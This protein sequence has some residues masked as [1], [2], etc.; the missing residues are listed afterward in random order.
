MALL[1]KSH[2]NTV[3][4]SISYVILDTETR[5]CWI[6]DVGDFEIINQI[7]E[8]YDLQGVFLTHIHYD[9]IYGLDKLHRIYPH[10]P[11]YTN[12]YGE[13]GLKNCYENLSFYHDEP[14]SFCSPDIL[15]IVGDNDI[16]EGQSGYV[17]KALFTP[18]HHSSSISWIV[19]KYIFTG[20]SYI[21]GVKVVTK[22]TG[23]NEEEALKSIKS[24]LNYAATRHIC[25]GH[26]VTKES[27]K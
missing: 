24:I 20:D 9:H 15:Q 14:F 16:I 12:K 2:I 27:N 18:G 21:P 19:D 1:V 8:G 7:I 11:I 13:D 23:G 26:S 3:F 10:V 6:V 5:K 25:P 22:L 4:H 17:F